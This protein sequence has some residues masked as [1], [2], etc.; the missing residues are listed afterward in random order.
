M[1]VILLA[2]GSADE[3]AQWR[4]LLEAD[5]GEPVTLGM[6][7]DPSDVEIAVVG[8]PLPGLLAALPNLTFVQSAWAGIDGLLADPALPDVP[9]AR[10]IDPNLATQMAESVAAYVLSIHRNLPAYGRQQAQRVWQDH[11]SVL[12]TDRKLGLLG[13]GEM[14]RAVDKTLKQIGFPVSV[15]SRSTG[16]LNQVLAESEILVNI[17]PL[18]A[19]TRGLLGAETFARMRPGAAIVNVGRGGHVIEADLIAA[20]DSGQLSHATLDVFATEPLPA[21]H[22]F[23]AHPKIT[24]TP[25]VAAISEPAST[26]RCMAA[27]IRRFRAGAPVLGLI[28]RQTGY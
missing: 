12:A 15:W 11:P 9:I 5:L 8:N 18:T 10:L 3:I 13:Y 20:L 7:E 22:P 26:V 4:D 24:I 19:E 6:P 14:G 16:D 2:R 1:S 21:D 25:H 27:N 17:L 28:S 23:W